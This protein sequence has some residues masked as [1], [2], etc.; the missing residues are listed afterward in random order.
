MQNPIIIAL[1]FPNRQKTEQFLEHFGNKP[2]FVKVGMELFYRE[3]LS[4]IYWLKERGYRVFLDLKLHDIPNTVHN[5]MKNLALA[6]ADMVNV[7]ASGGIKMMAAA[8]E[9]LYAGMQEKQKPLLIAVTQLTSTS[10]IVMREEMLVSQFTLEQAVVE[11]AKNAKNAGL[12]GVVSSVN[13]TTLI[14]EV[15]GDSFLTVTPG[16]RLL[17]SSFHDQ[18]RVASPAAAARAKTDYIVIGRSITEAADPVSSYEQILNEWSG[19]FEISHR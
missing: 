4:M 16:I 13:E 3:G 12:D 11:Y 2:L 19:S 15:C 7:H 5:A 9:G 6:G 17:G 1:D 8:K 18:E 10:E 14:K